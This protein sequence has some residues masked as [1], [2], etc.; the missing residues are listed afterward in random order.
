MTQT[1][2]HRLRLLSSGASTNFQGHGLLH[3]ILCNQPAGEGS[4]VQ[5]NMGD[6]LA[7]PSGGGW[8]CVFHCQELVTRPHL[9]A[10]RPKK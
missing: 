6:G 7:M 5:V 8:L 2:C 4:S 9:N 10:K 3:L 1:D